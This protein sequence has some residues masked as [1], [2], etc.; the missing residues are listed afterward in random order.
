MTGR[1]DEAARSLEE[2]IARAPAQ[3]PPRP[4]A[5]RSS[6]CSSGSAPVTRRDG[7]ARRVEREIAE[8]I[9]VFE[10]EGDEAGL[11]MAWRLLAWSAGTACRFGDAADAAARAVEH[12][13]RA[14]DVRQ[15][16]RAATAYAGAALLGPTNVDEAIARCEVVPRADGRRPAV[17]GEPPRDPRGLYA[18]QGSF[19]HARD[20]VDARP[21]A[22]RG[23]R[24]R[25]RRGPRRPRGVAGGD[26][27]GRPRRG[28]AAS[29]AG[30]TTRST[31]WA[32]STSSRPLP[33]CLAQTLARAR[34]PSR[35][36]RRSASGAA[37]SR[38]T[39]T[40]RLQALWRYVRG[41]MLA[42]RGAFAEAEAIAREAL[43]L[44]EPTDATM[45]QLD[46]AARPRRDPRRPPGAPDDARVGL[47]GRARASRSGR[48]ASSSSAPCSGA[49]SGS[50]PPRV[51]LYLASPVPR[52][53]RRRLGDDRPD[54]RRRRSG[55]IRV[56]AALRERRRSPCTSADAAVVEDLRDRRA[57]RW[58][59]RRRR[60]WTDLACL[61]LASSS[62]SLRDPE[63][64]PPTLAVP[65]SCGVY[66]PPQFWPERRD[67]DVGLPSCRV[68]A[69][70]PV[71]RAL[72][73]RRGEPGV[74]ALGGIV[75]AGQ[76]DRR[77]HRVRPRRASGS[78]AGCRSPAVQPARLGLV[79]AGPC[80]RSTR[81]RR[82]ATRRRSSVGNCL[83]ASLVGLPSLISQR[84]SVVSS[85]R[86]RR[87]ARRAPHQRRRERAA[88]ASACRTSQTASPLWMTAPHDDVTSVAEI[89]RRRRT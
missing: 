75:N 55:V 17:G 36:R 81:R 5:R 32:R 65:K 70:V 61:S 40:S 74:E 84:A 71:Q 58:R 35:R 28:R 72:R 30:R 64:E 43:E 59:R 67:A 66:V 2:A 15:E 53:V 76:A 87:G 4:P 57:R 1:F 39:A 33:D 22:V 47:R 89:R 77:R 62:A 86:R 19:D 11:A 50:T 31:R 13:Q 88:R 54:L 20:L 48:A 41:R 23:A 8:A 85:R 44:L 10:A 69:R 34:R 37:S 38:R 6:G 25:R 78:C 52:S 42:R 79:P 14:G 51:G 29:S 83:V 3:R 45:F 63:D 9:D 73:D 82:G 18:M 68:P 80:S 7:D 12:A 60:C 21:G 26:A 56:D 27:R 24:S 49:S 46:G 16:R